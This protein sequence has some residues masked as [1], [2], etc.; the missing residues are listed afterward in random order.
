[1]QFDPFPHYNESRS[2]GSVTI[3]TDDQCQQESERREWYNFKRHVVLTFA[4][5]PFIIKSPSQLPDVVNRYAFEQFRQNFG[6]EYRGTSSIPL[7][8]ISTT[9]LTAADGICSFTDGKQ[10]NLTEFVK[11]MLKCVL[12]FPIFS[13]CLIY[14]SSVQCPECAGMDARYQLLPSHLLSFWSKTI[15]TKHKLTS[16]AALKVLSIKKPGTIGSIST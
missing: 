14:L 4:L 3:N 9:S 1:M 10:D 8:A 13:W 7:D 12:P 2:P 15:Q 16:L 6:Y 11:R 5:Q